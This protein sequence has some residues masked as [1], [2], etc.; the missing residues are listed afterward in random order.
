[1]KEYHQSEV[2]E[3]R[4]YVYEYQELCYRKNIP[5]LFSSVCSKFKQKK[6]VY[7]LPKQTKKINRKRYT[8]VRKSTKNTFSK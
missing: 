2:S 3:V 5:Y 1:M 4:T 8:G 6:I 7:S